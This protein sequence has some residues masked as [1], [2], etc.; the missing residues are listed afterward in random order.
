MA[1]CAGG[2]GQPAGSTAPVAAATT[3]APSAKDVDARLNAKGLREDREIAYPKPKGRKRIVCAG[4]AETFGEGVARDATY[5]T[6]MQRNMRGRA[7]DAE[8]INAGKPGFGAKE[9]ADLL[10]NELL[11]Y[12]PDLVVVSIASGEGTTTA[13]DLQRIEAM[14]AAKHVVYILLAIPDLP[15]I[16]GYAPKAPAVYVVPSKAALDVFAEKNALVDAKGQ[17]TEF[18]HMKMGNALA[19]LVVGA[20]LLCCATGPVPANP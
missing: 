11:K 10:G 6:W 8:V 17:W 4:G 9:T 7:Y 16:P 14:L 1:A 12:E 2:G 5:E 19:E 15:A 3:A 13:A 20:P 18:A